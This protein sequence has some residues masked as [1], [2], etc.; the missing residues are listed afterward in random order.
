LRFVELVCE[1]VLDVADPARVISEEE[2]KKAWDSVKK[3]FAGIVSLLPGNSPA[4]WQSQL[5]GAEANGEK[6][7][8]MIKEVSQVCA[9]AL[10]LFSLTRASDGG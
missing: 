6:M 7:G 2:R 9:V 8:K 3:R 1:Y 5:K 4:V 10:S